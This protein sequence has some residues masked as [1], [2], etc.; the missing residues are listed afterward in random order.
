MHQLTSQVCIKLK[1]NKINKTLKMNSNNS[2]ENNK[3]DRTQL[4]ENEINMILS[5]SSVRDREDFRDHVFHDY[6]DDVKESNKSDFNQ[7]T[8]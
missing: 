6:K 1:S 4:S 3:K 2:D 7:I 8:E 5:T